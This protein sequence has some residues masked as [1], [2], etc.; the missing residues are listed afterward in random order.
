MFFLEGRDFENAFFSPLR[1][2]LRWFSKLDFF[3][4]FLRS[5]LQTEGRTWKHFILFSED[6]PPSNPKSPTCHQKACVLLCSWRAPSP[7][8]HGTTT[9]PAKWAKRLCFAMTLSAFATILER[10][11]RF[12]PHFDPKMCQLLIEKC[13]KARPAAP[14][15]R[16]LRAIRVVACASLARNAHFVLQK[17]VL[18]QS[19]AE[20]CRKR[21][22][23]ATKRPVFPC[24]TPQMP[25][26][27]PPNEPRVRKKSR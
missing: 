17:S 9:F 13:P 20:F 27:R 10:D 12:R 18:L 25:N 15:S 19:D 6:F 16:V 14:E 1:L 7:F 11:A 24:P 5:A 2:V 21:R 22:H 26:R 23:S 4:D 3:N 8:S